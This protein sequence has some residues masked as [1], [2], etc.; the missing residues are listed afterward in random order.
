VGGLRND[1]ILTE[2]HVIQAVVSRFKSLNY[3]I[4]QALQTNEKGIDIIARNLSTNK[5]ILVEA[6]GG[7]SASFSTSRF[8]K[9]FN[10]SQVKT[11]VSS[12]FYYVV[13]LQQKYDLNDTQVAMAFPNDELHRKVVQKISNALV[14]LNIMVYFVNDDLSV[15][16]FTETIL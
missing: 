5:R 3:V 15:I 6:K 13:M 8:G 14:R 4:E 12:A 7:T 11:H 16:E 10:L 9:P 2:N 1:T